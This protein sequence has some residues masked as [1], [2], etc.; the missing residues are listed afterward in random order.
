MTN[1]VNKKRIR[2]FINKSCKWKIAH[3][4]LKNALIYLLE[5]RNKGVDVDSCYKCAVCENYHIGHYPNTS[6]K[7]RNAKRKTI[8]Y[9][10]HKGELKI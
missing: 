4:T 2:Y 10:K 9:L 6:K 5:K 7:R 8:Y 3:S 1:Q